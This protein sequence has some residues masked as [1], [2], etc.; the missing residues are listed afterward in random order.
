MFLAYARIWLTSVLPPLF[1]SLSP[2]TT[3]RSA[4]LE[5]QDLQES[6]R[7]EALGDVT[8]AKPQTRSSKGYALRPRDANATVAHQLH[9]EKEQREEP[10]QIEQWRVRVTPGLHP[11][12]CPSLRQS[13]FLCTL[14]NEPKL[15]ISSPSSR[16]ASNSKNVSREPN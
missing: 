6:A 9:P 7:R 11:A 15:S 10:K 8:N 4:A 13:S 1:P 14:E 3:R 12:C 16:A 2:Q 5:T